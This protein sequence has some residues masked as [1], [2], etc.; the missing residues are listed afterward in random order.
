[1][2]GSFRGSDAGGRRSGDGGQLLEAGHVVAFV[3]HPG[4][5][6][7]EGHA[8]DGVHP[9]QGRT[10]AVGAE[11]AR[12]DERA[13]EAGVGSRA[14]ECHAQAHVA[15]GQV[16]L[17]AAATIPYRSLIWSPVWLVV[18]KSSTDSP[19]SCSPAGVRPLLR[20]I[21][22]KANTS[23]TVDTAPTHGISAS[24]RSMTSLRHSMSS[25]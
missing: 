23:S 19:M 11:G 21:S 1:M 20:S 5:Q 10:G 25:G 24:S 13:E 2:T 8:R 18:A 4:G 3:H 16:H 9:Q 22:V 14:G 12:R 15:R 17:R 7:A 6:E